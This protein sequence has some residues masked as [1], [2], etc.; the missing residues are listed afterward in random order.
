MKSN[1]VFKSSVALGEQWVALVIVALGIYRCECSFN[2]SSMLIDEWILWL[3]TGKVWCMC[4]LVF[5]VRL[6]KFR[7]HH[8]FVT[9]KLWSPF[10]HFTDRIYELY[11]LVRLMNWAIIKGT[12]MHKFMRNGFGFVWCVIF[13]FCF[14]IAAASLTKIY[15]LLLRFFLS[16][17]SKPVFISAKMFIVFT[18]CQIV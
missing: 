9:P 5:A 16:S 8:S 13:V 6:N 18:L 1:H 15:A 10:N 12:D 14:W 7:A 17:N 3:I 4:T 2:F 11:T